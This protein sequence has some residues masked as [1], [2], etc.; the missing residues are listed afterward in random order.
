MP[1]TLET[2]NSK[3]ITGFIDAEGCFHI[4]IVN[5]K[6]NKEGKSVRVIF[7]ISLHEKDKA[8]LY[9][10]K[11]YFGVG[12]VINR[13]DNV[14]YYQVTS[15]KDLVVIIEYLNKYPLITQKRVDFELFKQ[16]VYLI[17]NQNHLTKEGLANIIN[18]KASMN[19]KS[20]SD[21]IQAEYPDINPVKRPLM[22]SIESIDPDWLSGFVEG[23]GC[24]FVNIYKRKDSILGEGVKLVFKIT[25]DKRNSDILALF[26]RVFGS[27]KVY[28]Q[29]SKGGVLDFMVTGLGDIT[30]KVIPFFLAHPLKGAKLKEYQDFVK[31]AE[32]MQNK[33]HLTKDGFPSGT[34]VSKAYSRSPRGSLCEEE[35]RSI[36]LGMNSQRTD[37]S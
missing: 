12:K 11:D 21:F 15:T 3:F 29:S 18:I 5:S 32:L 37:Y 16:V 24:F 25:Q 30:G 34:Y 7:Q 31:V 19:F 20:I 33:A 28:S 6:S 26:S 8:L 35:I 23:E 9:Q 22:Q 1:N 13:G 14:Y 36:K 2:L 27:G 4:S 17:I 10:I